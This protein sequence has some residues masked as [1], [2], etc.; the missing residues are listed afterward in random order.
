MRLRS[1]SAPMRLSRHSSRSQRSAACRSR[2]SGPARA[3]FAGW[4]RWSRWRRLQGRVAYG[5]V[6]PEDVA[7]VLESMASNGPHP[8][9]LGVADEIP[10]LKRQTR[11]TFARCGVIDPRSLDD[12]RAHGGYKGL[13]ARAVARLGCDPQRSHRVRPAR[14]W[15]RRLSDRHQVEDGRA[16]QGG[17]KIHRL[18]R[19][20]R[21]QRHLRRPHDHGRRS[22]PG[23]RG[24]DD[25]RAS[26]SARPRATSTSAAN[27]RTRSRR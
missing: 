3:G 6:S 18:Q 21:R 23:H 12:Y 9:R 24:H 5:P 8:L 14:P 19:R 22:L 15:R 2:S 16:D 20:R 11:L 13:R 17:S 10:W 26:P 1:P 27:I 25:R 4:S 7:S